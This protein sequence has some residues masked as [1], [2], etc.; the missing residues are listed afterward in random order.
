MRSE[1]E[2]LRETDSDFEDRDDDNKT[3]QIRQQRYDTLI[4]Q[5]K[6]IQR[7]AVA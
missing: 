7:K 6:K 1:L 3:A 4:R 5:L 2:R